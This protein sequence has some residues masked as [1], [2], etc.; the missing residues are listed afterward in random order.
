MWDADHQALSVPREEAHQLSRLDSEH[1]WRPLAAGIAGPRL[2]GLGQG[3]RRA[4]GDGGQP[5]A[6]LK[7]TVLPCAA[8]WGGLAAPE[9]SWASNATLRR[10]AAAMRVRYGSLL[11]T[12]YVHAAGLSIRSPVARDR[13]RS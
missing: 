6:A 2:E 10:G 8:S 13:L 3:Q 11:R 5:V 1:H 4:G 7:A 9:N 12:G